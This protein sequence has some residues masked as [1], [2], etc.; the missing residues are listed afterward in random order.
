MTQVPTHGHSV[1]PYRPF[2]SD[3]GGGG[4]VKTVVDKD[5][6][7]WSGGRGGRGSW[8]VFPKTPVLK[9]LT[10]TTQD[11]DCDWRGGIYMS[12]YKIF[13]WPRTRASVRTDAQDTDER[14]QAP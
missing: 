12:D 9:P 14:K 10:L 6:Y 8:V 11:C 5:G 13:R 1:L 3:L 7:R 2:A 4:C